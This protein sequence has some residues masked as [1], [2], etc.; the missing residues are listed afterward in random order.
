MKRLFYYSGYRLTVFH[1][2]DGKFAGNY[3]FEPTASGREEFAQYL[4][5]SPTVPSRVLVDVI[6]EDFRIETIPHVYGKDRQVLVARQIERFFRSSG[7]YVW[8]HFHGR[9]TTGRRDDLLLIAALTNPDMLKPWLNQIAEADVP[10]RGIWSLPLLSA[11]ILPRLKA[12]SGN[13]FLISQ[14]VSSNIRLTH[15]KNG[16]VVSS[17]STTITLE[18]EDYGHFIADQIEQTARFLANKRSIGFDEA[19]NIHIIAPEE[20]YDSVAAS[21]ASTHL[22][23]ITIHHTQ[24]VEKKVDTQGVSGPYGNGIFAQL[25]SDDLFSR[26][27]YGGP[28]DFAI[29]NRYLMGKGLLTGAFVLTLGSLLLASWLNFDELRMQ[30]EIR[31]FGYKT[32]EINSDYQTR[33]QKLEPVL[34]KTGIMKSSVDLAERIEHNKLISPQ[35]F[36]NIFSSLLSQS[37]FNLLQIYDIEWHVQSTE[38]ESSN[39]ATEVPVHLQTSVQHYAI[40]KGRVPLTADNIRQAVDQINLFASEL[41]ADTHVKNVR[42]IK[43]PVDTRSSGSLSLQTGSD[44]RKDDSPETGQFVLSVTMAGTDT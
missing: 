38:G 4:K 37:R 16:K 25:C 42:L 2:I 11:K 3:Y 19:L 43:L 17:R 18:G 14:Q 27:H 28:A 24:D 13:V 23:N 5:K 15:F 34:A 44:A 32:A 9:E 7:R 6:E 10:V 22:R 31:N 40:L 20:H 35:Q 41:R 33:L 26:G 12:R 1:W 36:M 8:H 39:P 30:E 29:D 21:C